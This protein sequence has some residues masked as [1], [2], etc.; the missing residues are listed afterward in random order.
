MI[1]WNIDPVA[2]SLGAIKVHWYGIFF[3]LGL[4]SAFFLGEWIFKREGKDP[5]VLDAFFLYLIIG[6][7]LGARL[8]HVLFY[9]F[10]YYK[11]HL[12]EILYIWKGGLASHGGAIGAIIAVYLF[13][14]K[15]KIDFEWMLARASLG[16]VLLAPFIR[17]GNFF[18]SEIVGL[19]THSNFGVVFEKIDTL[20][21]HPVQLYEALGYFIIFI[22]TFLIYLKVDSKTFTKIGT[23][24]VLVTVFTLRFFLEYVKTPQ[25][26]FANILPLS[27]GQI[28][29]IPF[30]II[31]T[32]LLLKGFK[33][34]KDNS[35]QD[36]VV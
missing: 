1:H 17:I 25:S 22:I 16:A 7:T 4:L 19:H 21:R 28:L 34:I 26:E 27:M 12:L 20:P 23:G 30:I 36:S 29:S 2:L 8:A 11:E 14:K 31:G 33:Q 3:A 6:I 13:C 9:D 35:M 32:I 10:D 24:F 5:K 18:N 15:Y